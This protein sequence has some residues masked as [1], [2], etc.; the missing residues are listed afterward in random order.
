MSLISAP[1]DHGADYH[2]SGLKAIATASPKNFDFVKSRGA[3]V[4]YDYADRK[5]GATINAETENKL[6]YAVDCISNESSFPLSADAL[7]DDSSLLDQVQ[8]IGLLPVD[9]FPRKDVKAQ[10]IIAYTASGEA[11]EKFGRHFPVNVP[12]WEAGVQQFK[13]TETLLAAG[14][15]VPHPADVRSGG[16]QG[17]IDGS[18]TDSFFFTAK[19]SSDTTTGSRKCNRAK[20]VL[21]NWSTALIK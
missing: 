6:L 16:L 9:A 21:E 12:H 13:R 20:L 5:A 3:D 8:F 10:D 14:K 19:S 2:R 7:S 1:I 15:L 11:F 4:V 17:V 18:V